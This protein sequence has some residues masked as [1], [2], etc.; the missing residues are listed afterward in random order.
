[1]VRYVQLWHGAGQ[2]WDNHDD[3][4]VNHRRLAGQC[5]KAIAALLDDL[6]RLGLF[7]ETLDLGWRIW[8]NADGRIT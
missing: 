6:K 3:L 7:E 2:P 4:E 8:A 5:D 1:M